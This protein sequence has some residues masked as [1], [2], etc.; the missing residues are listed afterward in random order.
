MD[1]YTQAQGGPLP[2]EPTPSTE[3]TPIAPFIQV[4]FSQSRPF[5]LPTCIPAQ[6]PSMRSVSQ[7]P[8]SMSTRSDDTSYRCPSFAPET[9]AAPTPFIRSF[10]S[11][12]DAGGDGDS[13]GPTPEPEPHAYPSRNLKMGG[14]DESIFTLASQSTTHRGGPCPR[15]SDHPSFQRGRG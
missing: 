11:N 10:V 15:W 7:T 6:S 3:P 1:A 8:S 14:N 2:T 9:R 12:R 4:P 5:F 13:P